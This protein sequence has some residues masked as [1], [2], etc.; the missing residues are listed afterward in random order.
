MTRWSAMTSQRRTLGDDL[1]LGHHDDPVGD[2]AD[3]VHVV[4]DEEHRHAL[5]AQVLDVAEQRLRQRGLTPAIGSSSMT[6]S[7][8]TISARAIS[9]SLRWPPDSEP[10]KSSRLASSLNRASS[11]SARS[12]ISFSWPRHSG[13]T[14]PMTRTARR[15]ARWRRAACSR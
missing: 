13:G 6:S 15:A 12:V 2:V 8:S 10:A 7:G 4:L 3:H 14:A 1:A 9:S 11:S 5:V